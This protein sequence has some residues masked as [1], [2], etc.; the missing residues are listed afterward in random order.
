MNLDFLKKI[1]RNHALEHATITIAHS[2]LNER[3]ILGGNSTQW[4]FFVYGDVPTEVLSQAAS[5]A[6]ERL[7]AGEKELA[8]SPYCGT[9]LVVSAALTG[10]ACAWALGS[11]RRWSKL[12]GVISAAMVALVAARPIGYQVQKHLTTSGA[13]GRLSI[14]DINRMGAGGL[15][16]HRVRTS[17]VD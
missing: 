5:E 11:E 2:R 1:R 14:R 10:L 3:G 6:L 4:G 8:I 13:V 7:R 17:P 9:N 16:V 12:P 15:T